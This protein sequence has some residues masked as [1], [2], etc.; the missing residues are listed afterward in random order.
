MALARGSVLLAAGLVLL[1]QVCIG[2]CGSEFK[3]S[4]LLQYDMDT[5]PKGSR[6]ADVT[7]GAVALPAV[8]MEKV[9]QNNFTTTLTRN[10]VVVDV[11]EDDLNV[12][13]E[14]IEAASVGGLLFYLPAAAA[15]VSH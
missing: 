2:L 9:R 13:Q 3:A 10:I 8:D 15:E 1:S 7:L 5:V 12:V 4:R 6:V 14:L 11:A